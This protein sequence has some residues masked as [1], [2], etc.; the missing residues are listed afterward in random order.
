M[1]FKGKVILITGGSSGIGE[2]FAEYFAK[3]GALALVGRN[4]ERSEQVVEKIKKNGVEVETIPIC[5]DSESIITENVKKF[6]RLDI[7]RYISSFI[8]VFYM[9]ACHNHFWTKTYS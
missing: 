1:S 2:A 8:I 7:V 5:I 4:A 6:S 3:E 9:F